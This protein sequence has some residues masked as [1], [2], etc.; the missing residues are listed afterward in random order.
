MRE[1]KKR[2]VQTNEQV[3]TLFIIV[4]SPVSGDGVTISSQDNVQS[5]DSGIA[6]CN[7][8][9]SNRW[10]SFSFDLYQKSMKFLSLMNFEFDSMTHPK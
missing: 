6:Q 3:V 2:K 1:Q 10:F 9:L 4:V 8:V 5:L 7:I